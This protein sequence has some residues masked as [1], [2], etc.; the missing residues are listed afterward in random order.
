MAVDYVIEPAKDKIDLVGELSELAS[1]PR[2]F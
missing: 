2:R 1:P